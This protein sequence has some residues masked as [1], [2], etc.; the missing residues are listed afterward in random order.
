MIIIV[1][2]MICH[3]RYVMGYSL[4][5]LVLNSRGNT[6]YQHGVSQLR[7]FLTEERVNPKLINRAVAHFT[8]WWHRYGIM[9]I[10]EVSE[11]I[12]FIFHSIF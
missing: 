12:Y 11:G 8:Y 9:L 6:L 4:T 1:Y 2:F 7:K 10:L 5:L 3:Y